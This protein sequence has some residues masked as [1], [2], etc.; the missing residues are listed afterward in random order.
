MSEFLCSLVRV[1]IVPHPNA[2]QIEIAQVG[3][4][5][6]IVKKGQFQDGDLGIYIP[7][8]AVVPEWL[9]KDMGMW[10]DDRKKG[11]LA[12][13]AGNR[14]KAIKL[15]GVVSQ[16]LMLGGM[17][18]S[19]VVGTPLLVVSRPAENDL[20]VSTPFGIGGDAAEFLGIVK[21]EP[22]LPSHMRGRII[23]AAYEDTHLY[24]FDNLKKMPTLF[25]DGEEVV[26]TE[27]IHGTLLQVGVMPASRINEKYYEGRV[28][29]SSKGMGGKGFILDHNDET[30]IY[31]QAAKKHGLLDKMLALSNMADVYDMPVFLLGEVFGRT[32]GGGVVQDLTYDDEALAFRAFDM[33]IGNRGKETYLCADSLNFQCN[34]MNILTVPM[35]YR[36]PYSKEV[37][38]EHT[39]GNTTLTDKKQIREGVV[40]KSAFE[41]KSRHFGRKIAK[42]V[43]NAYILRKD[44]DATEFT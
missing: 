42:S 1:K 29:I 13:G 6:S 15:R 34:K 21:H 28:V 16:G 4:Y 8:Q 43:S 41:S 40:V 22:A 2:D 5:Q 27:K 30:N 35:L 36:G 18:Y 12:G 17:Q 19:D 3:D 32:M 25:D 26:I 24:D 23:G 31:A 38:L 7:E 39:D 37:V 20:R 11:G 33:C 44:K 9:L 10:D 14:V